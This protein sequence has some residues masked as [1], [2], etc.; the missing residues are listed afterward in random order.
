MT[1]HPCARCPA[2]HST[3]Y[4]WPIRPDSAEWLCTACVSPL[5]EWCGDHEATLIVGARGE[6]RLCVTCRFRPEHYMKR[7]AKPIEARS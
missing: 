2:P 3:P 4:E 7:K 6:W 5:C 1:A